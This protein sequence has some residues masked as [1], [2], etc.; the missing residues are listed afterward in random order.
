MYKIYAHASAQKT[1]SKHLKKTLIKHKSN[2]KLTFACIK[3]Q[4][5]GTLRKLFF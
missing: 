3:K 1:Q 2:A 4:Q 5:I